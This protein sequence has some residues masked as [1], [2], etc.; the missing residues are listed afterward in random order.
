VTFDCLTDAVFVAEC[1]PDV[2]RLDVLEAGRRYRVIAGIG[3]GP[4]K[5]AFDTEFEFLD[6]LPNEYSRIRGAGKAPGS[7]ADILAEL[8]LCDTAAG[9]TELRWVLDVT[10]SGALASVAARLLGTVVE[11]LSAQFF[12][13]ARQRIELR[14]KG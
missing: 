4:V 7:S 14:A 3:F 2:Q 10:I 6:K 11:Q 1:A 13:V 5:A 12:D 8:F 9:G